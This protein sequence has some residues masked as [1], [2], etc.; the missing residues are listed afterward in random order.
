MKLL[1]LAVASALL[2]SPVGKS[3][4]SPGVFTYEHGGE[5][6]KAGRCSSREK[7]SPI[8]FEKADEALPVAGSFLYRYHELTSPIELYASTTSLVAELA[9]L[10]VGGLTLDDEYYHLMNIK[11]KVSG[12]HPISGIRFPAE[13]HLVHKHAISDKMLIVALPTTSPSGPQLGVGNATNGTNGT[14]GSNATPVV[15]AP[16]EVVPT[17]TSL[18]GDYNLARFLTRPAPVPNTKVDVPLDIL[19]PLDLGLWMEGTFWRYGGSLTAPPC[20]LGVSWLVRQQ[21]L[22]ASDAQ[23]EA[24]AQALLAATFNF[25]NARNPMPRN[26]RPVSVWKAEKDPDDYTVVAVDPARYAYRSERN[27]ATRAKTEGALKDLKATVDYLRN[28][29][30]RLSR[31]AAAHSAVL[32][33]KEPPLPPGAEDVSVPVGEWKAHVDP[34]RDHIIGAV[35]AAAGMTVPPLV[36]ATTAAPLLTTAAPVA[37]TAAPLAPA[38]AG[39][40]TNASGANGTNGTNGTALFLRSRSMRRAAAPAPARPLWRAWLELFS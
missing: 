13:I 27:I 9:G 30:S 31:G 17:L 20:G 23:V 39:N 21:P 37:T 10:G 5:D 2:R 4:Y 8:A 29:D 33:G 15:L 16:F 32:H 34:I 19:T 28:L 12:E 1:L 14:N 6:W 36:A 11:F 25:G 18:D 3:P 26:S 7:Q 40:A 35:A 22:Q 38:P 24:L